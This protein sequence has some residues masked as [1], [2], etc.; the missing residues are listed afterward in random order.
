MTA[1]RSSRTARRAALAAA[2]FL[3]CPLRAAAET[4]VRTMPIEPG[5]KQSWILVAT[6]GKSRLVPATAT[7]DSGAMRISAEVKPDSA[8]ALAA[9][10]L[11]RSDGTVLST[12]LMPGAE[13]GTAPPVA[14]GGG[15]DEVEALRKRIEEIEARKREVAV[16]KRKEAGLDAAD[17]L[18]EQAKALDDKTA[19][20]R[21]DAE[22]MKAVLGG[23]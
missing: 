22:R 8:D 3:F 19:R 9:A 17:A 10:V 23:R 7:V 12:P 6:E 5:L 1:A 13:P 21:E 18:A 4:F 14:A 20:A 16:A 2:L 15:E 11:L